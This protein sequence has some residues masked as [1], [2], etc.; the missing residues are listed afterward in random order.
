MITIFPIES[1]PI[2]QKDDDFVRIVLEKY[3]DFKDN[4]ILVIAH[5][6]ISRIE[7]REI[8]L[9]TIVP[10]EMAIQFGKRIDKDP[11]A[12]EVVLRE[13]KTIVR[14][15]Q[16][17]LICE[18]KQGFICAN[19]GVDL[20]NATPNHVLTLPE[21]P[22]A[23]SRKIQNEIFK[24][25]GKKVGVIISD[26]FGG[27]FRKGTTNIAI[28]IAGFKPILSHKGKSDLFGYILKTTEVGVADELATA[29]GLVMGQ[30]NEGLPVIVVRGYKNINI[31]L[32]NSDIT[33]AD[34]PRRKEDSL[35]W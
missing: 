6:I 21:D 3:N 11:R 16:T 12:V 35:F 5:T 22:D 15:S 2:F 1:L 4:D 29:A 31:T 10:S 27:V 33:I 14:M 25:T 26:T 8:D 24:R 13:S 30:S 17:L 28:G 23:T 20:S 9:S 34:V 7:G 32:D 19:A 18:T